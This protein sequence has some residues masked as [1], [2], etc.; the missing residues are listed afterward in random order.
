M[1]DQ[2]PQTQAITRE[3]VL[4]AT[5]TN[6]MDYYLGAALDDLL[7][8]APGEGSGRLKRIISF[9]TRLRDMEDQKPG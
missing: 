9:L 7:T 6:P 1:A 8:Y 4:E 2:K 3:K 5:L